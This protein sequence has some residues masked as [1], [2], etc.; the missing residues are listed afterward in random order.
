M[1]SASQTETQVAR[2]TAAD[3]IRRMQAGEPVTVLDARNPKAW[4]DSDVK[5]KGAVRIDPQHLL[6]S[7]GWPKNRLT[8]A[9]C[10]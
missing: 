8:V 4:A 10:T 9:Y 6:V 7:P 3:L 2:I 1:A 5:V